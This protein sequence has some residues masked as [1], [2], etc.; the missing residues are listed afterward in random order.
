MNSVSKVVS[1]DERNQ[2]KRILG[3]PLRRKLRF[4]MS[5]RRD[6]RVTGLMQ[7]PLLAIV[8]YLVLPVHVVPRWIPFFRR[9]D[10]LVALAIG[11]W[12]FIKLTPPHLLED[13]LERAEQ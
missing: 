11:L 12:V 2:I 9:L 10:N 1:Y 6:S 13:H 5:L 8:A 4:A 3:L 7:L